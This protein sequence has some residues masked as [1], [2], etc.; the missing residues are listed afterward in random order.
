M[1]FNTT[2][3]NWIHFSEEAWRAAGKP[4]TL[5]PINIYK[6][7]IYYRRACY[8]WLGKKFNNFFREIFREIKPTS[9]F[10]KQNFGV[11]SNVWAKYFDPITIWKQLIPFFVF[12][13]YLGKV[14][15]DHIKLAKIFS[16][17]QGIPSI[18]VD[19]IL[20]FP[21]NSIL[22]SKSD[23]LLSL[24]AYSLSIKELH[25]HGLDKQLLSVY[26]SYSRQMYDSMLIELQERYTLPENVNEKYLNEY[27]NGRSR[28]ISSVFF[29]ITIEWAYILAKKS[30]PPSLPEGIIALR[31]VRQLNDEIADVCD[32]LK[33]G[34]I[35]YPVL[36]GLVSNDLGLVIKNNIKNL[37]EICRKNSNPQEEVRL[38]KLIWN[39]LLCA[40]SFQAS[41]KVSMSLLEIVMKVI[42]TNVSAD[43]AFDITVLI[44]RRVSRLSLLK[45]C[46]WKESLEDEKFE[47]PIML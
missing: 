32:D 5:H 38:L 19:K 2:G 22:N 34:I 33:A 46:E 14:R 45:K 18:V 8:S 44:N 29:G 16:I 42:M 36:A 4:S 1:L 30:L 13:D 20:D 43:S 37:W 39:Q 9:S 41:A 26:L 31:K 35:T 27:I 3:E 12:A 10:I 40:N 7:P 11:Y 24:N 21:D 25:E 23:F 17:G 28:L 47:P 15:E 6:D